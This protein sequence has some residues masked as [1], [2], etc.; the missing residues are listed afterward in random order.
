MIN[1]VF[2]VYSGSL[3]GHRQSY[4]YFIR[5]Q[6]KCYRLE[7]KFI[8]DNFYF[9]SGGKI[10]GVS[11]AQ[12]KLFSN[13]G[14]LVINERIS[15]EQLVAL[16]KSADLIWACY[17]PNYD[18]SSGVLERAIQYNLP[19]IVRGGSVAECILMELAY[20]NVLIENFQI[21]P[22]ENQIK[23]YEIKNSF[24]NQTRSSKN[25]FFELLN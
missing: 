21:L 19:T 17:S 10:S 15:N 14:A 16:S 4:L 20:E 2:G 6:F 7:N 9:A 11:D 18:Q 23:S 25:K 24:F 22:Y 5:Q 13:S 8:Q 12:I 3:S 1:K